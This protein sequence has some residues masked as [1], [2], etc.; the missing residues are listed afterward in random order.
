LNAQRRWRALV[1]RNLIGP[2]T[3]QVSGGVTK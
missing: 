2:T 3:A 1:I